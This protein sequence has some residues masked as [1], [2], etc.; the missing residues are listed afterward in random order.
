M[1]NARGCLMTKRMTREKG[2]VLI[3]SKSRGRLFYISVYLHFF[4]GA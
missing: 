2:E 1:M 3:E 4:Q